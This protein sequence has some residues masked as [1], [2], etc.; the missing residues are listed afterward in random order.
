VSCLLQ[1]V[2][3]V[4]DRLLQPLD[5]A[6]LQ[7]LGLGE[8]EAPLRQASLVAP[9][10]AHL[11]PQ[12]A[13]APSGVGKSW[14]RREKKRQAAVLARIKAAEQ[15]SV[16]MPCAVSKNAVLRAVALLLA[17]A[18]FRGQQLP[19]LRG[20]AAQQQQQQELGGNG[21][22]AGAALPEGQAQPGQ[23][24]QQ[25]HHHRHPHHKLSFE[26]RLVVTVLREFDWHALTQL[27]A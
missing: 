11:G 19:P 17:E 8:Q 13:P 1:V 2:Q 15:A 21:G 22:E 24:P 18:E 20:S 27:P 6:L 7:K 10:P 14:R 3:G 16:L 26:E 12:P 23:Q 25:Q 5:V 4:M 9:L